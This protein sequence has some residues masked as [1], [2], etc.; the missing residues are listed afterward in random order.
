MESSSESDVTCEKS[1]RWKLSDKCKILSEYSSSQRDSVMPHIGKSYVHLLDLILIYFKL[2]YGRVVDCSLEVLRENLDHM[3]NSII[4]SM[5]CLMWYVH[6]VTDMKH[7]ES[8][9]LIETMF[10]VCIPG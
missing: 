5:N 8:H 10:V 6:L 4:M 2:L 9:F 1:C 7:I 3:A